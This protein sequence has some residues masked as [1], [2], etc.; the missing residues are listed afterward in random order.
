MHFSSSVPASHVKKKK[1]SYIKIKNSTFCCLAQ[2]FSVKK[3]IELIDKK[4]FDFA[5][6]DYG[7]ERKLRILR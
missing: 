6:D 5:G 7:D 3:K 4:D 1:K 2:H